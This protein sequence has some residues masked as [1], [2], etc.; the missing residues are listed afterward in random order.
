MP[1]NEEY[2]VAFPTTGKHICSS[3][4]YGFLCS[5]RWFNMNLIQ[6]SQFIILSMNHFLLHIPTSISGI[7]KTGFL[8]EMYAFSVTIIPPPRWQD[9]NIWPWYADS[10]NGKITQ[11]ISIWKLFSCTCLNSWHIKICETCN[12]ST[13]HNILC[14]AP[15]F[16]NMKK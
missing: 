4:H 14:H 15:I 7:T 8:R 13:V 16:H 5:V 10:E 3:S 2:T 9:G 12:D 11:W 6:K 1:T